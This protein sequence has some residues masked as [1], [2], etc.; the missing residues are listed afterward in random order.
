[1]NVRSQDNASRGNS[2]YQAGSHAH[3][4]SNIVADSALQELRPIGRERLIV[5]EDDPVTR[6]MLVGYFSEKQ[7]VC[8]GCTKHAE[9]YFATGKLSDCPECRGT[10]LAARPRDMGP[11]PK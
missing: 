3:R 8:D 2:N 11:A 9:E 10:M 1:M 5:V 7:T 6:T 4:T